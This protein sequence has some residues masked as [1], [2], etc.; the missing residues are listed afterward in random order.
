MNATEVN[1]TQNARLFKVQ[2]EA[3]LKKWYSVT[4]IAGVFSCGCKSYSVRKVACKHV[5]FI[6][7]KFYDI[8]DNDN[9]SD[10]SKP[11]PKLF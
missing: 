11:I 2:S 4:E 5:R 1:R 6:K 7:A 10:N 8:V 3:D 9:K